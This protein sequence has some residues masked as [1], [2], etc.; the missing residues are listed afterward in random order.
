MTNVCL[1]DKLIN[2]LF[3]NNFFFLK[4]EKIIIKIFLLIFKFK[5]NFFI[6]IFIFKKK[7]FLIILKFKMVFQT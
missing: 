3:K 2:K 7:F 6:L 4:N 1:R 5:K